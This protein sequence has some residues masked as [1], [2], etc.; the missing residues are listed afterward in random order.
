MGGNRFLF[1][2]EREAGRRKAVENGPWTFGKELLVMEEFD[3]A[4]TIDDYKFDKVPIWIRIFNVPL[5]LMCKELAEDMGENIGDLIEVDTGEDGTAVAQCLRVKVR[6]MV[7]EPLKRGMFLDDEE[8]A[9]G[10]IVVKAK[11]G[12]E[13]EEPKIWCHFQYE[14]LPDL[15]YTCGIMGH[16]DREC[17]TKLKRGEVAEYGRWLRY[18]PEA[19]QGG[20][21]RGRQAMEYSGGANRRRYGWTNS[22]GRSGSDGPSWRKN[23]EG[24]ERGSGNERQRTDGEEVTSPLKIKN[25]TGV[26]PSR[27]TDVAK[28]LGFQSDTGSGGQVKGPQ[29]IQKGALTVE[30]VEGGPKEGGGLIKGVGQV[31][32]GEN[33]VSTD[34]AKSE[35][36]KVGEGVRGQS[37]DTSGLAVVHNAGE[38]Q[39]SMGKG[40]RYKK[41][42]REGRVLGHA[43]NV[44][45]EK[46]RGGDDMVVEEL[47]PESK[48]SKLEGHGADGVEVTNNAKVGLSEQPCVPQ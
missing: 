34:E 23:T 24:S 47:N 17:K 32:G 42:G 44:L 19:Y 45:L 13:E 8:D 41:K 14:F 26:A 18:L 48:K 1:V 10:D 31:K 16:I 22:S 40:G 39:N 38:K 33:E 43:D 2:F 28:Q 36:G 27:R 3:T 25:M 12:E 20:E 37:A 46:K 11:G 4:K 35:A 5:G 7:K 29:I 30:V 21:E 6:I 15:C 9:D